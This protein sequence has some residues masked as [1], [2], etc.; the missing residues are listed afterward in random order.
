MDPATGLLTGSDPV[1]TIGRLG[2]GDLVVAFR[3][4]DEP[5]GVSRDLRHAAV[6]RLLRSQVRSRDRAVHL[7]D[8]RF[9]IVAVGLPES[10]PPVVLE[11]LATA[12]ADEHPRG[13]RFAAGYARAGDIPELA[14][15]AALT[16]L[17]RA[18]GKGAGTWLEAEETGA[19]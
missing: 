16:A 8:G 5:A 1:R 11:R 15:D 7:G 9:V 10:D 4:L 6:G 18:V 19:F 12:W 13:E 17:D 2:E 14:V 3:F